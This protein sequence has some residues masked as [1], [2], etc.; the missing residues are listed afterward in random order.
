MAQNSSEISGINDPRFEAFLAAL[1]RRAADFD[2]ARYLATDTQG[3][4]PYQAPRFTNEADNGAFKF[5]RATSSDEFRNRNLGR[6][7]T[8]D[9]EDETQGAYSQYKQYL[10][11][12][13]AKNGPYG[14]LKKNASVD[15]WKRDNGYLRDGKQNSS[16]SNFISRIA[17]S[18]RNRAE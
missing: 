14:V 9:W 7:D 8:N 1:R 11:A 3:N 6:L 2:G 16:A 5:N 17:A 18:S 10:Q 4:S 12:L 13:T 15:N